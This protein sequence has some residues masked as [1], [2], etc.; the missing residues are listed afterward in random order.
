[1]SA[2]SLSRSLSLSRMRKPTCVQEHINSRTTRRTRSLCLE[3]F[4]SLEWSV[5]APAEAP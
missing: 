3:S 2:L 5:S 1:M 4:K